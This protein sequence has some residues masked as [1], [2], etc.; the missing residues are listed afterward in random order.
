MARGRSPPVADAAARGRG[1]EPAPVVL[2]SPEAAKRQWLPGW[3]LS[4]AWTRTPAGDVSNVSCW[5]PPAPTEAGASLLELLG[6][7]FGG[8]SVLEEQRHAAK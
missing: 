4:G 2:W 3:F 5:T 8:F 6:T 7:F 1:S